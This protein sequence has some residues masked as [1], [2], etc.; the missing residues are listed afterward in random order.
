[1][2]ILPEEVFT[3]KKPCKVHLQLNLLI[4]PARLMCQVHVSDKA[5]IIDHMNI[6]SFTIG[7]IFINTK[8]IPDINWLAW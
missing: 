6:G 2:D 5:G 4:H 1:M 7:S 3:Y 8:E